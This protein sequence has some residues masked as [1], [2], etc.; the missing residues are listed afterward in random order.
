MEKIFQLKSKFR[1]SFPD[2]AKQLENAKSQEEIDMLHKRFIEESKLNLQKALEKAGISIQ[3]QD[4]TAPATLTPDDYNTLINARG[5]QIVNA[6]ITLIDGV[7]RLKKIHED[8]PF[9]AQMMTAGAISIGFVSWRIASDKLSQNAGMSAA[10]LAGVRGATVAVISALVT[11]SI[12]GIVIPIIYFMTK[13]AACIILL[14]NELSG[15][16]RGALEFKEQYNVHGEPQLVTTPIPA[17]KK[18]EDT[19]YATSGFIATKKIE[20][21][22]VGTQ[23]GFVM[24][25]KHPQ[26][27]S[28]D[29]AFGTENPL[30]S[31]SVDNNCYCAINESAQTA[32]EK[33]SS[34]NKQYSESKVVNGIKLSIRCNSGSG[35]IAYYVARVYQST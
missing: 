5:D 18:I 8:G 19:L 34:E 13:P 21:A 7:E 4:Y 15:D 17:P 26:K 10:A 27:G 3:E 33:T 35:S 24:T 12:I 6:L 31:L 16:L 32:A 20:K 25:Y 14:I 28:M 9:T 11:V 23:F 2:Y 22:L 29:L 1:Q 30:T